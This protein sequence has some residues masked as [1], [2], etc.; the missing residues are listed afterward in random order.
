[1]LFYTF[2]PQLDSIDRLFMYLRFVSLLAIRPCLLFL[3]GMPWYMFKPAGLPGSILPVLGLFSWFFF[4]A[5]S[6]VLVQCVM[7]YVH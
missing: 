5:N 3:K 1:M 6:Q 2:I 7:F 4:S